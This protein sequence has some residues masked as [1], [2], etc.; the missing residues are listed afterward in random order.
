VTCL[1]ACATRSRV[2]R[3]KA[4]ASRRSWRSRQRSG[5][6][7]SFALLHPACGMSCRARSGS[8]SCFVSQHNNHRLIFFPSVNRVLELLPT[9]SHH[10]VG[11]DKAPV[12]PPGC[13]A[14]A[15]QIR[16]SRIRRRFYV[17][18]RSRVSS[19][20]RHASTSTLAASTQEAQGV[21]QSTSPTDKEQ[22]SKDK[23]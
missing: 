12:W 16:R 6:Q 7:R 14:Q 21:A 17:R 23:V 8:L 20:L 4:V 11:N 19:R 3:P 22:G 13:D 1:V 18:R 5:P 15:L 2:G 9:R 10:G